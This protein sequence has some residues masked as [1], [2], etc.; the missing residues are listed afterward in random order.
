MELE[1]YL[2][3]PYVL[4]VE[5]VVGEDG[6]WTRHASY[7]ELG[8]IASA[9]TPLLAI[10]LLERQRVHLIRQMVANGEPVPTPRRPLHNTNGWSERYSAELL[11]VY[12]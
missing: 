6:Q 7:P 9:T 1:E 3:V 11:E 8:L 4:A 10:E 2:A 12:T 5:T